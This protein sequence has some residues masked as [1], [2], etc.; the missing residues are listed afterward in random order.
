MLELAG[1]E[2]L[3]AW[4]PSLDFHHR[5]HEESVMGKAKILGLSRGEDR[6]SQLLF[7]LTEILHD[8]RLIDLGRS[9]VCDPLA[10]DCGA[11]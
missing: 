7:E 2:L 1:I 10:L 6:L 4:H 9:I 5:Q 3:N 8:Y 11:A